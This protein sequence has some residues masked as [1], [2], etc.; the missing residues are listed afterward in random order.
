MTQITFSQ[1]DSSVLNAL[2]SDLRREVLLQLEARHQRREAE[3]RSRLSDTSPNSGKRLQASPARL[4]DDRAGDPASPP[5]SDR[6]VVIRH[7]ATG[8][9]RGN[10]TA[11]TREGFDVA[12]S[13]RLEKAQQV[14]SE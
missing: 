9:S 14:R 11:S 1:V 8:I 2:P 12:V 5:E 6:K 7:L 13:E 4:H 3:K 10:V